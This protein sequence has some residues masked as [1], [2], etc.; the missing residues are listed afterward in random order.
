MF[1]N[2]KRFSKAVSMLAVV[3]LLT[4]SF[5]TMAFAATAPISAGDGPD[6]ALAPSAG[7]R[8]V[9]A[10]AM[11]WYVFEVQTPV[12]PDNSRGST[13]VD[14]T[15]T[16]LDGK[17]TFE[18]WS[19]DNVKAWQAGDKFSPVGAGTENAAIHSDPLNFWQGTFSEPGLFYLV[20]QNSTDKPATYT[21]NFSGS[22][23][24][25]PS[26]LVMP[27]LPATPV[28]SAPAATSAVAGSGTAKHITV[29]NGPN[30]AVTPTAGAKT[31]AAGAMQWYIF[32]VQIPFNSDNT[33]GD[34]TV[35]ATLTNLNGHATFE[36]WSP[37]N[38]KAWQAGD[39]FSPVGAGTENAAIHSDPLNFWHGDFQDAGVFYVVVKNT[40]DQPAT[41]T[42]DMSGRNVLYPSLLVLPNAQ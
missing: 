4:M 33:R 41:Y 20:V 37:D 11:Q 29:G 26:Q 24:L 27:S 40:T 32:E 14:V 8:T 10:G 1:N 31:I 42:L 36:I 2:Y 3:A 23:V 21:L 35:D 18:V 12:N 22:N 16:N 34:T 17:A 25:F 15:L 6:T 5:A 38:V 13:T 7:A 39:K 28:V 19:P 9:A 30:T